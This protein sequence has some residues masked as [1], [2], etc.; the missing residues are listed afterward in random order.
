MKEVTEQKTVVVGYTA[1][2]GTFFVSKS[3]CEKYENSMQH[4][5]ERRFG[6][7]VRATVSMNDMPCYY[8]D[9]CHAVTI[10][11]EN[12]LI[13]ANMWLNSKNPYLRL[14][15]WAV[16]QTVAVVCNCDGDVYSVYT[17]EELERAMKKIVDRIFGEENDNAEA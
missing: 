4:A 9:V 1:D 2:D 3:E 11:N 6:E 14:D 13:A 17:K 5:I 8:D 15:S 10:R 16:G 12:D 7:I